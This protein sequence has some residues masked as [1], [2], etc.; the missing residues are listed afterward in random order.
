MVLAVE[1]LIL[2]MA[3]SPSLMTAPLARSLS[4]MT[5]PIVYVCD[6]AHPMQYSR[7]DEWQKRMNQHLARA[8]PE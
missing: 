8:F 5:A 2:P 3:L 1:S 7:I 4:L 6:E